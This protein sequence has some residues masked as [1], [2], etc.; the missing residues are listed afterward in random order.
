MSA[1]TGH[2]NMGV[3][4]FCVILKNREDMMPNTWREVSATWN[5]GLEF[6]KTAKISSRY[7]IFKPGEAEV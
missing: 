6:I 4:L 1:M 5:G 7:K 2:Y 3:K